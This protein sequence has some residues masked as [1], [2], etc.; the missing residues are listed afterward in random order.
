MTGSGHASAP[1][2][3]RHVRCHWQ[4]QCA[5]DHGNAWRID[6]RATS[7]RERIDNMLK[8]KKHQLQALLPGG[9]PVLHTVQ[10]EERTAEA[11][12]TVRSMPSSIMP[13]KVLQTLCPEVG[14]C[15]GRV[16]TPR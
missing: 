15:E 2:H 6:N 1:E 12:G 9:R 7:D 13:L 10:D 4:C 16:G 14:A 11:K 3:E 5:G 8:L